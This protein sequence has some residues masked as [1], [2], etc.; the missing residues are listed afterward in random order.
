MSGAGGPKSSAAQRSVLDEL[1]VLPL[2][3]GDSSGVELG[4]PAQ[5]A[6]TG[7]EAVLPAPGDHERWQLL[8]PA[9][10]RALRD[11]EAARVVTGPDEGVGLERSTDEDAV[12]EPLGLDELELP[13]QVS[14]GE[15]EDDAAVHPVF[16]DHAVGEH[17]PVAGAA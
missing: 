13:F 6:P 3:M 10:D 1:I 4:E 8:Q 12:V 16:L 9:A 14:T 15:D 7:G 2:S 17:R 11:R 5:R